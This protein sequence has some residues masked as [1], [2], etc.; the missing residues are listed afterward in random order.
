MT[1]RLEFTIGILGGPIQTMA[2][3][4]NLESLDACW[5]SLLMFI[6]YY[7]YLGQL[8]EKFSQILMVAEDLHLLLE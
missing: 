5:P 3:L 7:L 1:L 8:L 4:G 2:R 6:P